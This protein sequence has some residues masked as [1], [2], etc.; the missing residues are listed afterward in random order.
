MRVHGDDSSTVN[1]FM[2][3]SMSL[4]ALSPIEMRLQARRVC[5]ESC[6]PDA[7]EMRLNCCLYGWRTV[8]ENLVCVYD[9]GLF[10]RFG[11][12]MRL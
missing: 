1:P 8:N 10:R 6:S 9:L 5:W 4:T 7:V 2:C 12:E 3:L 11:F